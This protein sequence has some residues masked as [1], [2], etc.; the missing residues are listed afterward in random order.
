MSYSY[1]NEDR[2]R[3]LFDECVTG[4]PSVQEEGILDRMKARTKST[5]SN[6]GNIAKTA[7]NTLKQA[8]Q[9][10]T[11]QTKGAQKTQDKLTKLGQD[12]KN[13]W[14]A[15]GQIGAIVEQ[16][17][18]KFIQ[19]AVVDFYKVAEKGEE[20]DIIESI[21]RDQE[22]LA[23]ATTVITKALREQIFDTLYD[24]HDGIIT[25]EREDTES[26]ATPPPMPNNQPT[27]PKQQQPIQRIPSSNGSL[28][29]TASDRAMS[30]QN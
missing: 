25:K 11:G 18:G 22:G 1:K 27:E 30:P 10:I 14:G 19:K 28:A 26:S 8:G 13:S 15:F 4:K 7:G 16:N 20:R 23:E 5:T 21:S 2:I 9:N 3:G 6:I 12:R 24:K 29:G 17:L